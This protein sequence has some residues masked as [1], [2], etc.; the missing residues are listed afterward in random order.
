MK[1]RKPGYEVLE[2]WHRQ[3]D[4]D[5]TLTRI[6]LQCVLHEKADVDYIIDEQGTSKRGVPRYRYR[7]YRRNGPTGGIVVITFICQGQA[8]SSTA[9]YFEEYR[10]YEHLAQFEKLAC[11]RLLMSVAERAA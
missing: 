4:H 8:D 7:L 9:R 3:A 10:T 6:A 5:L 1:R 11:E 2:E